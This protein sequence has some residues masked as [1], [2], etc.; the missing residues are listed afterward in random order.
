[1]HHTTAVVVGAGH[2]GLA[3]SR[4]LAARSVD[5][6][7]LERGEVAASW[8]TQRW[9]SLRLLTPNWMTRLPGFA[10]SG[11]DPDGYLGTPEVV[12]FL[13]D[14][15]VASAAPVRSGVTV[16]SI[17]PGGD[18]YL[19]RTDRGTWTAATVVVATGAA[20]V[21]AV[22][23]VPVPAAIATVSAADY[24]NPDT[25]PPGGV[26]VV[27]AS[28]SGVQI[29]DELRCSGRPVTLAVG[30]HV[31]MP[32]TY[33]GRDILWWLDAAGVL[34][35]RYD[36]QPDLVRARNLPSMQ[37]VGSPQRATV[38]LTTL[39]RRGVRLVGRFAGVRDG[40]AQFSGSLPNVCALADLKLGRLLNT[41]DA[42]AD[43]PGID[44]EA[45]QRFAPTELP[46]SADLSMRA[47]EGGIET[48]VWATG[49]RPDLSFVDAGVLDRKGRPV[50]DG[51]VTASPGLY[52]IGLPFLRRRKSTL[53]DG[54][55]AD[56]RELV[57]HLIT[58]LD[59]LACRRAS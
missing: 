2:C 16:T 57:A 31:R 8:R 30:E 59:T 1:M 43:R 38:D 37:L 40:V 32:R 55:A 20:A 36:A 3:V 27:G 49:Y 52:L 7:V 45:P 41:L 34:D 23:A 39:R 14:Y 5:H 25:L 11:A 15:A 17:R 6:V 12:R 56:A 51:G 9:D 22:P 46:A 10:Y 19:V 29:A 48:I 28:A 50:H 26:L 33:R 42:W 44:V 24:R 13:E 35:E 58:H 4:C 53:I 47:G 21:P 18:G 54:A